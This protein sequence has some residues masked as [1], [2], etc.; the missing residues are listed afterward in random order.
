[1]ISER[2]EIENAMNLCG[3]ISDHTRM[4]VWSLAGREGK[5]AAL[6]FLAK[7]REGS[8]EIQALE[9]VVSALE[10]WTTASNFQKRLVLRILQDENEAAALKYISDM[11][12]SEDA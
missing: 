12:E 2:D 8:K 4:E 9:V 11:K 7:L 5:A 1:M 3:L 6:D 10:E